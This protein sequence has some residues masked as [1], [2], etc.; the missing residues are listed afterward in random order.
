MFQ[1]AV[2]CCCACQSGVTFPGYTKLRTL[3]SGGWVSGCQTKGLEFK[4]GTSK[5]SC[6]SKFPSECRQHF[7]QRKIVRTY[8]RLSLDLTDLTK[9]KQV[10]CIDGNKAKEADTMAE[11]LHMSKTCCSGAHETSLKSNRKF[12]KRLTNY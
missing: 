11:A 5:C 9:I 3:W 1:E 4:T 2:V 10:Y 6:L 12:I 8:L 7:S